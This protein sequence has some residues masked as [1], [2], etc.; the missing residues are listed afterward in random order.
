[1]ISQTSERAES[2]RDSV[3]TTGV[4]AVLVAA[5]AEAGVAWSP[6]MPPML[7]PANAICAPERAS[8]A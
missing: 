1:M 5:Q 3:A 8:A 2:P 7:L 6:C 4:S